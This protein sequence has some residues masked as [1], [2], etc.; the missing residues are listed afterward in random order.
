MERGLEKQPPQARII[1][2]NM[3]Q[4][5][6]G[7]YGVMQKI[8]HQI[9]RVMRRISMG[10]A[11]LVLLVSVSFRHNSPRNETELQNPSF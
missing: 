1:Y 10:Y 11:I 2:C 8:S 4:F 5:D 9:W 3:N 6:N 7:Y